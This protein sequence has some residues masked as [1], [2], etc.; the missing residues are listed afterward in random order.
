MDT[1]ARRRLVEAFLQRCVTYANA[2]IER[3]Q[4]RGDDEAE[5]AKWVAYRDFTEHAVEEVESGDLDEWLEG[6]S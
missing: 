2:S 1:A 4:Q 6:E 3:R 5:I